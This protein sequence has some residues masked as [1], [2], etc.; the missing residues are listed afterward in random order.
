MS[1]LADQL[2]LTCRECSTCGETLPLE[3]FYPHKKGR[4]GRR[5]RCKFCCRKITA[6]YRQANPEKVRASMAK[7]RAENGE[8]RRE[9][10]VA[11]RTA[12]PERA[13]QHS[14]DS[15][16]RCARR[17]QNYRLKRDYG[18]TLEQYEDMVAA[19]AGLCKICEQPPREGRRLAVD[20]DHGDGR[21]RALLCE[22]CNRGIGLF[23][24]DPGL[25]MSAV[26]YLAEW[27]KL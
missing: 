20:H 22:N 13:R 25:L 4:H 3:D 6:A 17:R 24:E 27:G 5:A 16:K 18:I 11:W 10:Q 15:A 23:A 9:L 19:Q 26:W 12:N 14:R 2:T 8:R 1:A 7:W 21:V